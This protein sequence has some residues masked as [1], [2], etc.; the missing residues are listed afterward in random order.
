MKHLYYAR[1][2]ESY[3]NIKDVFA[4]R[5]GTP[6]DLGLTELGKKQ[7]LKGGES[8]L[9]QGL[10]FDKILCSPLTRTRETADVIASTI[11]YDKSKIDY[12]DELLELQF[13]ELEGTSWNAFWETG[14]TYADLPKYAEAET[15]EM[16]QERA[17]RA[18]EKI[19]ELPDETILL[20]SHSAYGRAMK[21][22]IESRPFTDEFLGKNSLPHGEILK[23]V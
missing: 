18:F 19:K 3:V 5:P 1:H 20:V 14:K 23:Y 21:R 10:M 7:A 2:G 6:N 17:L 9:D 8:A 15:I 13:G 4:T 22:A 11:G 12:W 16:M